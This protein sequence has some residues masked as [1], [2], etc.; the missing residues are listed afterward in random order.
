MIMDY[1]IDKQK[2][3]TKSLKGYPMI[4]VKMRKIYLG[5]RSNIIEKPDKPISS[6][7]KDNTKEN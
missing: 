1:K 5:K 4:G 3:I 2:D 7:G 6:T